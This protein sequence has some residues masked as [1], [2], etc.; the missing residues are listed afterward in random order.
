ML[1]LKFRRFSDCLA[2]KIDKL[3]GHGFAHFYG[4]TRLHAAARKEKEEE[5]EGDGGDMKR[6]EYSPQKTE[7]RGLQ[8][9]LILH[10]DGH[11]TPDWLRLP[12]THT[13]IRK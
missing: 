3:I 1:T 12:G 2:C 13:G 5:R 6:E 10:L 4:W 11:F 9:S 8:L 7:M